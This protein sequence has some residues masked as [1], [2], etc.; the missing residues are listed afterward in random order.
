MNFW[1]HFCKKYTLGEISI[2]FLKTAER[3]ERSLPDFFLNCRQFHYLVRA[4][5]KNFNKN[6]YS[7]IKILQEQINKNNIKSKIKQITI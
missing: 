3:K 6:K 7:S 1:L 5:Q 4:W 2:L